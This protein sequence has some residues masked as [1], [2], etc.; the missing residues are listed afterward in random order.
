VGLLGT[1]AAVGNNI[2]NRDQAVA[3]DT[4]LLRPDARKRRAQRGLLLR[5]SS[6]SQHFKHRTEI[7]YTS[8]MSRTTRQDTV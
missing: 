5:T 3:D 1:R 2:D 6:A 4:D 7:L 8:I